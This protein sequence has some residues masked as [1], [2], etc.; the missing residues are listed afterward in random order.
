MQ[1]CNERCDEDVESGVFNTCSATGSLRESPEKSL[2]DTAS[3]L[4]LIY[5]F[6]KQ[7]TIII[8]IKTCISYQ[9]TLNTYNPKTFGLY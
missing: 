6:K 1:K 2:T 5:L 4:P 9:I 8:I 7:K 3:A